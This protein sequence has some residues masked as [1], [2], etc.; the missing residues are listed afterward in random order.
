MKQKFYNRLKQATNEKEVEREYKNE[1]ENEF[2]H[3]I[4]KHPFKCDGYLEEEVFY[5]SNRNILRLLMEF[6][7][8]KG[9]TC[10]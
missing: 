4:I 7:Y 3:S 9:A 1:I 8:N 10:C 2:T 5:D 6:K